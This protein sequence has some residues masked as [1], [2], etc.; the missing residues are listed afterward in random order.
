MNN[1]KK[2]TQEEIKAM[3]NEELAKLKGTK[4]LNLNDMEHAAGGWVPKTHEDIDTFWNMI[5]NLKDNVGGDAAGL[6]ALQFGLINEDGSKGYGSMKDVK[7]EGGIALL[8][9]RM[10]NRLDAE[11]PTG[12]VF[13]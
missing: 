3:V 2:Y 6:A 8:C 7:M 5:Q 13:H 4:E 11:G 9:E 10:H 1:E 12:K